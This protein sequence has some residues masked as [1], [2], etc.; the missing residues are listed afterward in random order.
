[1]F[2]QWKHRLVPPSI[3]PNDPYP[4]GVN[5]K[6]RTQ[7]P[8]PS[9]NNNITDPKTEERN[10]RRNI[11]LQ[12]TNTGSSKPMK[13]GAPT[14]T[15]FHTLAQKVDEKQFSRISKELI[16]LIKTVC[17]TLPCPDCA[18][19]AGHYVTSVNWNLITTKQQLIDQ[20]WQFHN[21]VNRRKG[22]PFFPHELLESTYSNKNVFEVVQVFMYH[23]ED[24]HSKGPNSAIAA[25]YH[26]Q[27]I[28]TRLKSWFNANIQ[29]FNFSIPPHA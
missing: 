12:T 18:S 16:D 23:Y 28:S 26:R 14:W 7:V 6:N 5:M 29:S 3:P 20:M 8:I 25:K 10:Q 13:W 22:F 1:M 21:D 19:H 27:R 2:N 9:N 15:L 24:K 11:P 4:K 17:H